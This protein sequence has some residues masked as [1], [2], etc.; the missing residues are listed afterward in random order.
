MEFIGNYI[1]D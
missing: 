1:T